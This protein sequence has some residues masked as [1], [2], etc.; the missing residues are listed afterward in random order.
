MT[1]TDAADELTPLVGLARSAG[2]ALKDA[3]LTLATAESCTGGLIGHVLTEVAGSSD[4][5]LGGLVSY[6]DALKRNELGV[7]AEMLEKHGAV[8]AQTAV[9]MAEGARKRYGADVAVAVTGIA[10][11]SGGSAAK[12]VGLTYVAV[13]DKDGH[14]VQRHQWSGDRHAN[15]VAS[16]V[17]AL[18]LLLDRLT[19]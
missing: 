16:A 6:S 7:P 8:S 13:A 14:E 4:Y 3:G 9:A 15:K 19:R 18:T 17:A 12:P 1:G 11:P 5:Y 2:A 10:G